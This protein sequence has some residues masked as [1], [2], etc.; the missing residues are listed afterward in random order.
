M[1]LSR[2][3]ASVLHG[4]IATLLAVA[5]VGIFARQSY[6]FVVFFKMWLGIVVTG[7][8]NAFL[9]TPILLSLFGPTPDF[10][11]LNMSR[12]KNFLKRM[13]SMSKSQIGAFSRQHS[14]RVD[15]D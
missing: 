11:S 7:M 4:S 3:G 1:A 13:P 14:I 9:L 12:H 10:D 8:A 6:F 5:I 2:I 15:W